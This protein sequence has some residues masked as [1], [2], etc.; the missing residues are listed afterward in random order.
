MQLEVVKD[1]YGKIERLDE[2]DLAAERFDVIVSKLRVSRWT[3]PLSFAA[4]T[5]C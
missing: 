3:S 2:L 1:Y 5:G 4:R